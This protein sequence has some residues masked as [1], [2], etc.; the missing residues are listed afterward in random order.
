MSTREWVEYG[1]LGTPTLS[2]PDIE[3]AI[4]RLEQF[5]QDAIAR[6]TIGISPDL[7]GEDERVS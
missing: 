1:T 3:S 2:H 4:S 7:A 5:W 6:A